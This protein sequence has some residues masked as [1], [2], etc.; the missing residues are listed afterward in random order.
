[1]VE[2]TP[3]L[4]S[5]IM[6]FNFFCDN[7]K[8]FERLISRSKAAPLD[9]FSV[10]NPAPGPQYKENALPSKVLKALKNNIQRMRSRVLFDVDEEN[11]ES[12]F[13]IL[14]GCCPIGKSTALPC[15]RVL[16]L[17]SFDATGSVHAPQLQ[18]IPL[19][20]T[21]SLTNLHQDCLLS[22]R[23][24]D[25]MAGSSVSEINEFCEWL[26]ALSRLTRVK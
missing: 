8:R 22:L 21:N 13:S 1:M 25:F 24:M 23:S 19:A 2:G 3:S 11:E 17:P 4:W 5:F 7:P 26:Q 16:A 20:S 6:L 18:G 12:Y 15:L 10:H 9:I 14:S